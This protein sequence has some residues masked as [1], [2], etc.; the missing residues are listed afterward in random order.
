MFRAQGDQN[1]NN[2]ILSGNRAVDLSALATNR[3]DQLNALTASS[4]L[5]QDQLGRATSA[6]GTRLSGQQAQDAANTSHASYGLGVDQGNAAQQFLGY[7]SQADAN[8]A[9]FQRALAL[10]QNAQTNYGQDMSAQ[11]GNQ[12]ANLDLQK[13]LESQAQYQQNLA[14]QKDQFGQTLKFNYNQLDQNG[15]LI[16]NNQL[17][18]LS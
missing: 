9:A 2:A 8:N 3:Q 12:S 13:F 14:A 1:I 5:A 10:A 17:L 11:L 4:G 7:Q 6:Y 16:Q 18:G 15:N